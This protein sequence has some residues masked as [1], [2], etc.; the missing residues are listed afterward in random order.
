MDVIQFGKR[1]HIFVAI[2]ALGG[3]SACAI[4]LRGAQ[5]AETQAQA[6]PTF[7]AL[8]SGLMRCRTVTPEQTDAFEQCRQVWAENRRRF[9]GQARSGAA[10]PAAKRFERPS[11]TRPESTR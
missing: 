9:L 10:A 8:D 11:I 4:P 2:A 1:R 6:T 7:D 3:L 5:D